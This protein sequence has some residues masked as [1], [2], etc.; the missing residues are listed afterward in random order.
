VSACASR[1]DTPSHKVLTDHI[2]QFFCAMNKLGFHGFDVIRRV[3]F[4]EGIGQVVLAG[5]IVHQELALACAVLEPMTAHVHGLGAFLLHR[6]VG[7]PFGGGIVNLHGGGWLWVAHLGERVDDGHSVLG[8]QI[9][10]ANFGLSGGANYDINEFS[11]GKHGTI[12]SWELGGGCR[13]IKR[14]VA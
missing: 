12:E 6:A 7:K 2:E 10:G 4:G 3:M 9:A 5:P 13:G 8:I 1:I 11:Q 14:F